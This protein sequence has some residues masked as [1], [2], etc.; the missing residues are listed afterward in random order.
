MLAVHQEH[1]HVEAWQVL[2]GRGLVT[3]TAGLIPGSWVMSVSC[4]YRLGTY[5]QA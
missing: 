5:N 2:L 3:G 1:V 4:T